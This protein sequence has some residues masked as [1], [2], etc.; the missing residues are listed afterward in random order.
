MIDFFSD[1]GYRAGVT[2]WN[3]GVLGTWEAQKKKP[4]REAVIDMC[5]AGRHTGSLESLVFITCD[6]GTH[7]Y[8]QFTEKFVQQFRREHGRYPQLQDEEHPMNAIIR[9]HEPQKT[10]HAGSSSI[11]FN[12]HALGN[13]QVRTAP[14]WNWEGSVREWWRQCWVYSG[15][16]LNRFCTQDAAGPSA[17]G[18]DDKTDDSTPFCIRCFHT[19]TS[20]KSFETFDPPSGTM[21]RYKREANGLTI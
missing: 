5:G 11:A 20:N 2:F 15:E 16:L 14:L 1:E 3:I 19:A 10:L 21:R 8:G 13:M 7:E 17:A 12:E 18:G 4:S 6:N 9:V